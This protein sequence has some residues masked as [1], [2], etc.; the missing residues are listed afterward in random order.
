MILHALETTTPLIELTLLWKYITASS[1]QFYYHLRILVRVS[2]R[3]ILESAH[4]IQLVTDRT[5]ISSIDIFP[6][7][8]V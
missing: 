2:S 1:R 7:F 3:F 8:W 4:L 6:S 5:C